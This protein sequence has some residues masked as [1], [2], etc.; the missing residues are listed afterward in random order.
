VTSLRLA[1]LAL[2]LALAV[3]PL[4]AQ[5]GAQSHGDLA[6]ADPAWLTA[7]SPLA[8]IADLPRALPAAAVLPGLL[9][10]PAPRVGLLWTAGTPAALALEATDVQA[11]LVI[12]HGDAGGDYRRPLDA[13]AARAVRFE[14]WGWGPLGHRGAVVGRVTVGQLDL[15]AASPSDIAA[16]YGSD[17]FVATDMTVP[18]LRRVA[19]RLEGGIGGRFG[20]WAAGLTVGA[21]VEDDHTLNSSFPRLVKRAVPGV[22]VGVSRALPF[23]P[24]RLAVYA[25]WMGGDETIIL[26][27]QPAPGTVYVLDGYS[28]PDPRAVTPQSLF[29]YRTD[30]SAWADGLAATG[31]LAGAQWT[32]YRERAS[33]TDKHV[34]ARRLDAPTDRWR[35][36]GSAYG[37]AAQRAVPRYDLLLTAGWRYERL[38]GDATRADLTGIIFGATEDV[39]SATG[40]VRYAPAASP[41]IGAATFS[42]VRENRRREDFIAETRSEL[43]TWTPGVGVEVARVFGANAVAAGYAAAFYAPSGGIPDP[44]TMGPI[45]QQLVA[46]EQSLYATRAQPSLATVTLRHT[47]ASGTA[48]LLRARRESVSAAGDALATGTLPFAPQGSRT[49]WDVSLGVVMGQ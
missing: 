28:E 22:A 3:R 7:W 9:A 47:F 10:V 23:A 30:R 6:A 31:T 29:F 39:W 20:A 19:A 18:A 5:V 46:S 13:N 38:H 32:L 4:A 34:S 49:L 35:A 42:L 8:R 36:T 27:G 41:W 16:P 12:A 21:R 45:Y 11:R 37:L 14:G 15:D 25:R 33:R 43:K 48:V 17:P 40:E 1:A 24:V 2:V 44:S 26:P